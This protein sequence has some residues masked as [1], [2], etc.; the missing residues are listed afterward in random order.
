MKTFNFVVGF[1]IWREKGVRDHERALKHHQQLKA[2]FALVASQVSEALPADVAI[3][4]APMGV[5]CAFRAPTVEPVVRFVERF[6]TWSRNVDLGVLPLVGALASGTV[7]QV[8][9]LNSLNFEGPPAIAIARIL[10]GLVPG[11]FAVDRSAWAFV[12]PSGR[13]PDAREITAKHGETFAIRI[14]DRFRLGARQQAEEAATIASS[15]AA[16]AGPDSASGLNLA[17]PP[18][19]ARGG[20]KAQGIMTKFNLDPLTFRAVRTTLQSAFTRDSLQILVV[21]HARALKDEIS[22]TDPLQTVAFNVATIAEGHGVLDKLLVGAAEERPHRVDLRSLVL[23]C[24]RK[25]GWTL[26]IERAHEDLD[27]KG[28]LQALTS[29]GDPFVDTAKLVHW[30][31]RVERQVCQVRCGPESGTGFLVGPDLVLTCYH[32]VRKHLEGS[33][34]AADV[35][36]R[37]D[38]RRT[39]KGA[40]PTP[41]PWIKI[42]PGWKIPC[43]KPSP[44]DISLATD[45]QES[46]L[47]FALLKLT[48]AAGSS[49][50]DGETDARGW[51]DLAT[52]PAIADMNSPI[53]IVQHPE[54]KD[55]PPPQ[56]PL[57]I[58]F[59]TPGFVGLNANGTRVRYKPS[60][61]KGS[62]G[63]PVYDGELRPV[64]L[65]HNRGQIDPNAANLVLENRGVPLGRIR[66]ALLKDG[67]ATL[68]AP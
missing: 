42:A 49:A 12:W 50:P 17:A 61:L 37:F 22:W 28:A 6:C 57:K 30:L 52:E 48:V 23:A 41:G 56:Q 36:V 21:D 55:P 64:A 8:E 66:A 46:E 3:S 65:H 25:Q 39:A 63:S 7:P 67:T 31:V 33:V 2:G 32:V 18:D 24:A 5:M 4:V 43:S 38:Y 47:D 40:D 9:V 10:A 19:R 11:E 59:A 1:G 62:S 14:H 68:S 13:T 34:A 16:H 15:K 20:R 58:A 53:L 54:R 35:E 45:P 60:T 44:A 27:V 51:V 29:S 26:A